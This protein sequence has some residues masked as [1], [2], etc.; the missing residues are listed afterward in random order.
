MLLR[1]YGINDHAMIR[2]KSGCKLSERFY[3][4]QDNTRAY[5]FTTGLSPFD[6]FIFQVTISLYQ[7]NFNQS[8]IML[9]QALHK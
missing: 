9:F 1:D 6:C 7:Y 8:I 3:V 5:Y 4:R 2:F